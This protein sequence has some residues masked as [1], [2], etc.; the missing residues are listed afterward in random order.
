MFMK[1]MR[2][3]RR[4]LF[5]SIVVVVAACGSRT[6]LMLPFD[7]DAGGGGADGAVHPGQD[8]GEEDALPPIDVR[9]P[10]DVVVPSDCPDASSTFIYLISEAN[11][12][13][14][15]YPPAA[16]LTL[17]GTIACPITIPGETPFSMAVDRAG[18]AYSVFSATGPPPAG[19][20]IGGELFRV[21]TAT[22]ACEPTGFRIGQQGFA[23]TFG[24]GFSQTDNDAGETLYVASNGTPSQLATIDV[25][26]GYALTPIGPLTPNVSSAELT[27]TGGGGLFGFWNP[28]DAQNHQTP[29][30][31][32]VQIDKTSGQVTNSST[33]TDL[34]QGT[35]WAF[36]FWGGDF[37]LFTAPNNTTLVTRFRPSDGS[38]VQ[39][40]HINDLIV[41]AGV[42]TCAPQ[43]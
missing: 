40:A 19:T 10:E 11:Q 20:E 21:S 41:G 9:V 36:A 30:S 43:Q 39:V 14:S 7:F 38:L 3:R 4:L 22:A 24:M 12:L 26:G 34:M 8:A 33:L 27:G 32:I 28:L 2:M 15:F 35:G 29:S 23:R 6:G 25:T 17:I 13:Y 18:V 5:A 42:S 37:Y 1:A 31:A 16:E